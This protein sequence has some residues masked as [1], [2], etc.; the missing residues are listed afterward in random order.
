MRETIDRDQK[1]KD[2]SGVLAFQVHKGPPMKVQFR[3]IRYEPLEPKQKKD[4][5]S[6]D[7]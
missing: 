4:K 2:K 3:K 1:N 5:A 7:E 6:K